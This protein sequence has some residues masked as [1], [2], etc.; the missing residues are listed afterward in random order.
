MGDLDFQ[1]PQAGIRV[2]GKIPQVATPINRVGEIADPMPLDSIERIS[3]GRIHPR[4][5]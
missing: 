1:N 3:N 2:L 5:R 4:R